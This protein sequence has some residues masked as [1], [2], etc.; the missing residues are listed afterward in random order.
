MSESEL[1]SLRESSIACSYVQ[2]MRLHTLYSVPG[3][4]MNERLNSDLDAAMQLE[5]F[6]R[7]RLRKCASEDIHFTASVPIAQARFEGYRRQESS[8]FQVKAQPARAVQGCLQP[9]GF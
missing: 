9:C 5:C 6:D 2:F 3:F 8:P 7:T 1:A 4:K